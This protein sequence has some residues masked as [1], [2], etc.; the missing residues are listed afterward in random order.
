[1]RFT[2]ILCSL[3]IASALGC[4][5]GSD[6]DEALVSGEASLTQSD[7]FEGLVGADPVANTYVSSSTACGHSLTVARGAEPNRGRY[8]YSFHAC[9]G[10][11]P[12]RSRGSF[13]VVAGWLDGLVTDPTLEL[14]PDPDQPATSRW[15]YEIRTA[16]GDS[17]LPTGTVY[18][19]TTSDDV[20]LVPQ[21]FLS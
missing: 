6:P 12:K 2:M 14:T 13:R 18:L 15:T 4:S 8:E 17:E 3:F 1:M 9:D 11:A 16:R 21:R 10:S 7:A 19:E 5:A 20:T